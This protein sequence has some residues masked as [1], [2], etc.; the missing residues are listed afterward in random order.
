MVPGVTG[1]LDDTA[2]AA[3][4]SWVRA[5]GLGE[6]VSDVVPLTGGSQNVVVRL[7]IDGRRL[8]AAGRPAP[9]PQQRPHD[10]TRDRRAAHPGGKRCAPSWKSSPPCEDLEVP[11]GVLLDGRG[12]RLQPGNEIAPAHVR[13]PAMR[14]GGS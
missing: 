9:A 7:S 1:T 13:D 14:H 8:C 2:V 3:L 6:T 11:G 12:G 10:A 5:Q 4:T